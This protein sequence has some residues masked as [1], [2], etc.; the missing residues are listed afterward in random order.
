MERLTGAGLAKGRAGGKFSE[1][2]RI[3]AILIVLNLAVG[4][5]IA[6]HMAE[7]LNQTIQ[8]AA[9][10]ESVNWAINLIFLFGVILL[11]ITYRLWKNA[12]EKR[13]DLEA[14]LESISPDVL[15]VVS[16][17]HTIDI[18]S[19]SA[20][21]MLGREPESLVGTRMDEILSFYED[22]PE[23]KTANQPDIFARGSY[24]LRQA[25]ARAHDGNRIFLEVIAGPMKGG[26]GVVL[27][28]R[29]VTERE[30]A[31]IKLQ[32]SE[33]AS[34]QIVK[35][36]ADGIVIVKNGLVALVNPAAELIFGRKSE[37]MV[38]Q[39]F[40]YPLSTT[41]ER[42]VAIPHNDGKVLVVAMR[43]VE[44][45]WKGENAFLAT[46]RDITERKTTELMREEFVSTVTDEF[47]VVEE[48]RDGYIPLL[49]QVTGSLT[50][51]QSRVADTLRERILKLAGFSA[52]LNTLQGGTRKITIKRSPVR[53]K[54]IIEH[55]VMPFTAQLEN[56]S[57]E[58]RVKLSQADLGIMGDGDKMTQAITTIIGNSIRFASI[59]PIDVSASGK[60][61]TVEFTIEDTGEVFSPHDL[62]LVFGR[63]SR[64][65]MQK[66]PDRR[67]PSVEMLVVRDIL[68]AHGGKI[69]VET[70]QDNRTRF[71]ITLPRADIVTREG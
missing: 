49:E 56:K 7:W 16:P 22:D 33:I 29:D 41:Q 15:L 62:P 1:T 69:W 60:G 32:A 57:M 28:L 2:L 12:E 58:L 64:V 46:M 31:R 44:L 71:S 54:M 26:L 47:K 43:T 48:I 39:N 20:L 53:V 36:S 17:D 9:G 13:S 23:R 59:S 11:W 42:E 21:H 67:G 51:G 50:P 40:S 52:K 66:I 61:E 27:L 24:Q 4:A 63:D 37:E 25:M 8:T 70:I 68:E 38:G 19:N 45:K 30:T 10:Q 55:A 65:F 14:I 35:M 6:F 5:S 18:C 34:G 3:I